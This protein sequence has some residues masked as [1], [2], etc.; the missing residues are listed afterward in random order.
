MIPYYDAEGKLIYF[1]TR[2]LSDKAKLRYWG[3]SKDEFGVGKGDVI[4]MGSWPEEGTKVYLTEGEFDAMAL[5]QCGLHAAAVGGKILSDR[6][7]QMLQPYR[8]ALAFDSDKAGKDVF[9]I[10]RQL[11]ESPHC[12]YSREKDPLKIME[13]DFGMTI[14]RPPEEYKDWNKF[15]TKRTVKVIRKYIEVYEMPCDEDTLQEMRFHE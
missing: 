1:N 11:V 3:P 12:I 6:Q 4:W 15:L 10:S 14:I 7:M 9:D 13:G 8:I 5:N 2:A